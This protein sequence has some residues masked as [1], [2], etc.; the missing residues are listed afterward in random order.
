MTEA[1]ERIDVAVGGAEV[2]VRRG[3][4]A[5][6]IVDPGVFGDAGEGLRRAWRGLRSGRLP[7]A[8][9]T[10]SASLCAVQALLVEAESAGRPVDRSSLLLWLVTESGSEDADRAFWE[11]AVEAGGAVASP[12]GFAA[13]LPSAIAG[14]VTRVLGLTGPAVVVV[15]PGA[16][17][18]LAAF[19]SLGCTDLIELTLPREGD[20]SVRGALTSIRG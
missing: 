17:P 10:E 8:L 1:R 19:A 5:W 2:S 18:P 20:V 15:E 6:R 16:R 7:P 11:S 14:E 3:E 4:A 9:V 13:T 12:L